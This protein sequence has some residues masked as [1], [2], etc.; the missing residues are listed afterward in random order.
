MINIVL[1]FILLVLSIFIILI[2]VIINIL[3][4][5]IWEY[6]RNK[7]KEQEK[8]D[9]SMKKIKQDKRKKGW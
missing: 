5:E 8:Y 1:V 4:D 7:M 6:V 2:P 9:K 3:K